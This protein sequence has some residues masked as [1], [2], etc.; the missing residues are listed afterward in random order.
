MSKPPSQKAAESKET[1]SQ[2]DS[3]DEWGGRLRR[4][5]TGRDP[6]EVANFTARIVR[7]TII[8][9]GAERQRRFTITAV[10]VRRTQV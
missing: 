6:I 9:D 2:Q 3:Y 1:Q 8:D 7:D 10:S 5:K 4:K